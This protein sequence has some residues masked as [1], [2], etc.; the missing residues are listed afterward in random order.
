MLW[1][2]FPQRQVTGKMPLE[3]DIIFRETDLNRG[4]IHDAKRIETFEPQ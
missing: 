2:K 1:R 3:K 4:K